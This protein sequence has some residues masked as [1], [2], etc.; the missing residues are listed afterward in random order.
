MSCSQVSCKYCS[1]MACYSHHPL[2][3]YYISG[4]ERIAEPKLV[5]TH[6][7][8]FVFKTITITKSIVLH[9]GGS[10]DWA[11]STKVLRHHT[12]VSGQ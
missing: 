3:Y 8:E 4:C 7:E 1:F 10:T 6:L 12:Y 9:K 5:M 2:C 11:S